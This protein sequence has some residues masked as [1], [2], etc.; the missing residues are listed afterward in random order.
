MQI[1]LSKHIKFKTLSL[2][3]F[4][5]IVIYKKIIFNLKKY[6]YFKSLIT[7]KTI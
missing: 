2:F 5:K 3:G 1:D 6:Y 7:L 4:A